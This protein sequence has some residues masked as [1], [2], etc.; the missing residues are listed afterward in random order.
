M[1]CHTRTAE[2]AQRR[3]Q[4]LGEGARL[5]RH[6]GCSLANSGTVPG[7]RAIDR[8]GYNAAAPGPASQERLMIYLKP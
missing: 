7:T 1:I 2:E 8:S 3:S 5:F 4:R 6:G